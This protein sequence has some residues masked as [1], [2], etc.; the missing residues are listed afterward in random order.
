MDEQQRA[1][2]LISQSVAA[3]IEAMGMHAENMQRKHLG[4]SMAYTEDSFLR[5]IERSGVGHNA[6]LNALSEG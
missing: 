6:A 2:F 3:L 1:A 5:L 4:H